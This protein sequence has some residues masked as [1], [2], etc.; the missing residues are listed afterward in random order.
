MSLFDA[1]EALA[2]KLAYEVVAAIGDATL[3]DVLVVGAR[4]AAAPSPRSRAPNRPLPTAER[5]ALG[6]G[7]RGA[8]DDVSAKA[9]EVLRRS[10]DGLRTETLRTLVGAPKAA[11]QRVM[12]KLVGD[13]LVSK[14]GSK[15]ATTYRAA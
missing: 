6:R 1:I 3:D 10:P 7:A 11:Y 14:S 4:S 13:G 15:R 2:V 8:S 9:I 12:L 5:T